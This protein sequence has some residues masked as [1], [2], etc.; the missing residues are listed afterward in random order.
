ML[1]QVIITSAALKLWL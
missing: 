1:S